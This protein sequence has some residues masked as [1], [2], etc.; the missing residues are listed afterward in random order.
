MCIIPALTPQPF[1]AIHVW[2][3]QQACASHAG[4]LPMEGAPHLR[5]LL[6][7]LADTGIIAGTQCWWQQHQERRHDTP[8][9]D[10]V[11]RYRSV[12][13]SLAVSL[14]TPVMKALN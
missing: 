11:N 4:L 2:A 8:V 13:S 10:F 5:R 3:G 6:D 1:R 14:H 7:G 9:E 12:G